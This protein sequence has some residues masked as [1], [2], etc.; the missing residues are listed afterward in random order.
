MS[1]PRVTYNEPGHAHELTFTTYR[2]LKL[3]TKGH[4][5]AAFLKCLDEARRKWKFEVWAYVIMPEHVHL[6]IRPLLRTYNMSVIRRDIKGP[7]ARAIL[8]EMRR[9][10]PGAL[11]QLQ[12]GEESGKPI[13]RFWQAGAG[14]D[15]NLF[16][17][18][19]IEASILYIHANPVRRGLCGSTLDWEWSSARWYEGEPDVPF[20]VDRCDSVVLGS[21]SRDAVVGELMFG[22]VG[23]ISK[24]LTLATQSPGLAPP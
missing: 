9:N 15:R 1:N 8:Q 24:T 18:E 23:G 11:R 14:Y 13:H 4:I 7:F 12:C 6:V 5:N 21:R 10:A 22:A 17:P 2:R 19:A 16:S 20:E 3:L